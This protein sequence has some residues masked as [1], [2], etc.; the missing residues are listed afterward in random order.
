MGNLL[1]P[2]LA[3]WFLRMVEKKIS[4]LHLV[5]VS[6]VDNVFAI[7]NSSTNI[8]LFL[9]VLN[10]QHPNFCFTCEED[11]SPSLPFLN[12]KVMTCYRELDVGVHRKSTF[13]SAFLHFNSIGLLF[14]K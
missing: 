8:Q 3:N 13:T 14:W 4:D 10:N 6:Y 5:Y 11:P 12:V 2:T 9:N 7:F 1:G